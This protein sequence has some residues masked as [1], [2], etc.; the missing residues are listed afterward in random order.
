MT[1]DQFLSMIELLMEWSDDYAD[2]IGGEPPCRTTLVEAYGDFETRQHIPA[3]KWANAGNA[4]KKQGWEKAAY[5]VREDWF[6][7][8]LPRLE[9]PRFDLGIE[10]VLKIDCRPLSFE[11]PA[12]AEYFQ[13]ITL[14]KCLFVRGGANPPDDSFRSVFVFSDADAVLADTYVLAHRHE[15]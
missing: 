13:G 11:M 2:I 3:G 14:I 8:V 7:M 9:L 5:G 15:V 6:R 4:Y 10:K 12:D 1:D